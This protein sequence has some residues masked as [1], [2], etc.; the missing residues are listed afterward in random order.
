M[1]E[2]LY[3]AAINCNHS[4]AHDEIILRIDPLKEGNALAQLADRLI[5]ASTANVST[6]AHTIPIQN[7]LFQDDLY[8]LQDC[9][10][11]VG[12]DV[13]FWAKDG[14]GYTTDL[15]M[16]Q[17][18][19][20]EVVQ[21]MHLS[22]PTDI[23]WPKSYIDKKTRPAVDMQYLKLDEA[24]A[25]TGI[26]LQKPLKIKQESFQCAGCGQFMS[27]HDYYWGPCGKCGTE[28]RP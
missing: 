15:S 17:V 7:E 14:N 5:E 27:Q 11:F 26:T 25:G 3:R 24:L 10:G 23:P 12:N 28:N 20:K 2:S 18:Y 6:N 21:K 9:R 22:R 16:A 1:R 19:S 13:V 8:Y 4:I